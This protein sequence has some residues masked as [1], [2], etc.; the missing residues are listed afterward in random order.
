MK[1]KKKGSKKSSK[2]SYALSSRYFTGMGAT[3]MASGYTMKPDTKKKKKV[4][5]TSK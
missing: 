2:E 3:D 5:K 1:I 4:L